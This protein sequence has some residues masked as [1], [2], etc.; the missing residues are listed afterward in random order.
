MRATPLPDTWDG[1]RVIIGPD[2]PTRDD[3]RACEYAVRPS[4]YYPGRWRY[5]VRVVLDDQDRAVIAAGGVL[6]LELDGV[7]VPWCIHITEPGAEVP[8]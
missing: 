8:E 3:L 6:W 4:G 7:E 5:T 1:A 2:D